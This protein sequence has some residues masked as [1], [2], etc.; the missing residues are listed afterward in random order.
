MRIMSTAIQLVRRLLAAGIHAMVE[1]VIK[2][3]RQG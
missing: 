2:P 3:A 1:N